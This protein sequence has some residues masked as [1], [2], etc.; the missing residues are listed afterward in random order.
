M[1][2]SGSTPASVLAHDQIP[3]PLVLC[4]TASSIVRYCSAGCL[5]ATMTFTY[6]RLRR[7]WSA[8]DSSVLASGGR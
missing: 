8:T 6:C 3:M 7:Q 5:P 2:T 4:S 1:T